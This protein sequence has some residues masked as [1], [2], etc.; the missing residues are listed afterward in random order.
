MEKKRIG[1]DLLWVRPTKEGNI[2]N[3]GTYSY[4]KNILDGLSTVNIEKFVFCLYVSK[5]N[6]QFF[7]DY[8][9]KPQFIIRVCNTKSISQGR[10]ILWENL[11][12]NRITKRDRLDVWFI[13]VF[14]RPLLLSRKAASVT[15]IHDLISLHYP[16]N[17]GKI[18]AL[19]FWVSW[20]RDVKISDKVITIS[21]FCKKDIIQRLKA[22]TNKVEVIYNP[23]IMRASETEFTELQNTYHIEKKKYLYTVSSLAKHKNLLTIIKALRLL[24]ESDKSVKLVIT[25]V[26][27]NDNSILNYVEENGLKENVI[28]TGR[29][30]DSIRDCLYDNCQMFLFPSVFEGFGM[31][32]VEAMERNIPVITTKET[33]LYEVTQGKATYVD[34]PYDENEWFQKISGVVADSNR[35]TDKDDK[36][37]VDFDTEPYSLT[38]VTN[39]YLMLFDKVIKNR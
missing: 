34:N 21:E 30:S 11:H 7:E 27:D 14:S 15:V 20:N 4:I 37:Y 24:K 6:Q 18:R 10:R 22:E 35:T 17:Y 5:D 28:Y 25:G 29:I 3:G 31:P 39:E 33:A 32:A 8:H 1:V 9:N 36:L 19:Y 26:K 23:I 38:N 12:M 13:P 16:E 2:A